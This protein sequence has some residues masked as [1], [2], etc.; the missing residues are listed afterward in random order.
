[1]FLLISTLGVAQNEDLF[2][3]ANQAYADG[4]YQDAVQLYNKILEN[5]ETSAAVHYNLGNAHYKLNHIAPSIYHYEKALKMAPGDKDVKNNLAF[6]RNMAIDVIDDH[7]EDGFTGIFSSTTS[8]FTPTGWGWTAVISMLVFVIFFLAYYFTGKALLKR[9]LFITGIFFFLLAVS[10]A[11]IGIMKQNMLENRSFAIIFSE[12]VEVKSEP[13]IR[14][15][16]VFSLHE[17][18]KVKVTEDFQDWYEIELPNG[19]QGWVKS[20][21][22]KLL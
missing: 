7:T 10:S 13:N 16:E 1:M 12:E 6:A 11:V 22:L 21:S 18:A 20:Q 2:E 9:I 3:K 14:S 5:G 4:K 19:S 17:G 8:I 15:T